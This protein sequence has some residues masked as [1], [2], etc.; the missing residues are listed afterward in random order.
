ME[1]NYTVFQS[2]RLISGLFCSHTCLFALRKESAVCKEC[3][4]SMKMQWIPQKELEACA[5]HIRGIKPQWRNHQVL[6]VSPS[7]FLM[8]KTVGKILYLLL[9]H[10][11]SYFIFNMI[12]KRMATKEISSFQ[13]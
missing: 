4:T 9:V 11:L 13:R 6:D 1:R 2:T 10:L 3:V 7:S 5:M 12:S 8:N